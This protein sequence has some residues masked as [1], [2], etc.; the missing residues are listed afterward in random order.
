MG[1]SFYPFIQIDEPT[2]GVSTWDLTG[3]DV[4][5]CK[6]YRFYAAIAG[7]RNEGNK[8]PLFSTRGLPDHGPWEFALRDPRP[9][10]KGVLGHI[11]IDSLAPGWLTLS[12]IE[13]AMKHMGLAEKDRSRG[14]QR[15]L[16]AMRHLEQETGK[17]KVRLVFG[18]CD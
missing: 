4:S 12:E 6:D 17:D 16:K 8:K 13:A 2:G 9:A 14:V 5:G 15:I 7:V 1:C 11:L 10:T 18:F 3:D